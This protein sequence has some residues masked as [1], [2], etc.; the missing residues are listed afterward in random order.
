MTAADPDD[1]FG[2]KVPAAAVVDPADP[3]APRSKVTDRRPLSE[4]QAEL[5][6]ETDKRARK[7]GRR[8]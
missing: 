4:I 5:R 6:D 1:V 3:P 2:P 7:F 8:M